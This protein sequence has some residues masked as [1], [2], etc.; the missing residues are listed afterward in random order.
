MKL[1]IKR[2]HN[3]YLKKIKIEKEN[4][5]NINFPNSIQEINDGYQEQYAIEKAIDKLLLMLKN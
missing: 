3:Q 2:H 5:K 1:Q 4:L